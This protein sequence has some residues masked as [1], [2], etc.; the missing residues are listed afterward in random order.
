MP[1][2]IEVLGFGLINFVRLFIGIAK[3]NSQQSKYVDFNRYA[4]IQVN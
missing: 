2:T 3:A 4:F 1:I